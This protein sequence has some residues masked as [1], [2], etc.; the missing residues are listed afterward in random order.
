M[1]SQIKTHVDNAVLSN[2]IG[3]YVLEHKKI[4]NVVINWFT[5]KQAAKSLEGQGADSSLLRGLKVQ[6][7]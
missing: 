1:G 5:E 7:A 6:N 2:F 4:I 3:I